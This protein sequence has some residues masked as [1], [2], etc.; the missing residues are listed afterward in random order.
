[1][2]QSVHSAISSGVEFPRLAEASSENDAIQD[3]AATPETYSFKT[4]DW[5]LI[6]LH[7]HKATPS[8]SIHKSC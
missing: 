4:S 6:C 7:E 8:N 3:D 5:T 1:M 2:V